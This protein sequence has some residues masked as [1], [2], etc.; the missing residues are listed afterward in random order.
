MKRHEAT[1]RARQLHSGA[2]CKEAVDS[3][4]RERYQVLV[5]LRG[6]T[7]LVASG[8]N[9]LEA[10]EGWFNWHEENGGRLHAEEKEAVH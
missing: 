8:R 5:S 7:Y 9:W 4:R 2:F 6:E 1:R 10:L 3:P